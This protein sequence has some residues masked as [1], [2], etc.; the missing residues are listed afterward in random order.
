M[1]SKN[2]KFSIVTEYKP[3][4]DQPN[5]IKKLI[6]GLKNNVKHQV[7]MGATGTGKTF[8]MANVIQ[9]MNKPTLVLAHNKTLAM[10]L[11]IELKE[12]FPNNRVE[13]YV[14]NFDFYQPEAY[15]PSRDLY[16][17]K[18]AKRNND[19]EMMRLSSM[20]ALMIRRDTIVVAS[21]ACIYATQDPKEYGDVFFELEVGQVLSKKEL[22]TFLV[23]TGYTRDENDLAMGYFS[24][25]GDVIRIAPSWTDKYHIRISMFGDE[26]EAIEMID[27]LNNTVLEKI[28]MFTVYP[29][30]A[31]VTNFD[32]MKLVVEN[33][34]KELNQ[35]VQWFQDQKKFIEADRL[36]KRT[37]YDMETMSEFGICSG[38][39]N[40]SP[41]LDFRTPGT[42]PFTLI[43]YFGEDF[44]TI[45]DESHMM[46]PQLNAMY[47]TD[48]S[49]KET[50]VEHGFRLPSA[51]DNRPLK[52][53]EFAGKLKNVI[54]TSATP[55]PY[56]LDLVNNDVIEQIIRPT[57]LVDPQIEIRSTINQ[58]NDIVDE[59]NKV[60][61]KKQKVFITAITIR[62]SEDITTY[63]QSRNLKVAYLHSELKT[64]ERNQVL[65]DLRKGVYDVIVGVNL[66]REGL[67]I[68]EVSLVC[69]LDA[70]KQGFLRNTRSLIQT[71][72][73]AARNSE[74]R[75][76]FYA[77]STSPA[78]K[79]AIEETDRRRNIQQEYNELHGIT[80][81]T[82]IKKITDIISD[83]NIRNKVDELKK[84]K[85]K[86]K[87]KKKEDLISD[88]RKQML[89]VAKEQNYEKA[90]ELR[91]LILEL[92]AE[93]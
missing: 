24:A 15:I 66:L 52:F 47:N 54:Y 59:I 3:D 68:P 44:L 21:V 57:G 35:R 63:L 60:V 20:N 79:E 28:R 85:K 77:D 49:R 50:L 23:Q 91:D 90:A 46:I 62:I 16:I 58:M 69:I 2:Q 39:E 38:I 4:G 29:A 12:L 14:S 48:R 81:K 65:T 33:I 56:E 87:E 84:L 67:D 73:R 30:A 82:I 25:K 43:D 71:I 31:Y 89:S 41:H 78:M 53:Q 83:S 40:Y 32:K 5:A 10:Q 72:G 27:V 80:P 37:K 6:S 51:I 45:I 75:V 93:G 86:E 11:Y 74:G 13:Y 8:T 19:L 42:P 1:E 88:L 17:D 76:I 70:D 61:A 22:L 36:M 55:G 92:Q 34:G 7:L 64:L 18:D 9:E 26:I